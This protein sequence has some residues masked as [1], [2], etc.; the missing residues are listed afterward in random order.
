MI[1]DGV[2][3]KDGNIE[4]CPG[5]KN[6]NASHPH[7]CFGTGRLLQRFSSFFLLRGYY[8]LRVYIDHQPSASIWQ[9]FGY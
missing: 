8:S 1:G 7:Q 3:L 5:V 4:I 9:C 6:D 2:M